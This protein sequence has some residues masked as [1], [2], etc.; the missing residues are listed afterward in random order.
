MLA[1]DWHISQIYQYLTNIF[2]LINPQA[3]LG[4]MP[5]SN[6]HIFLIKP[7]SQVGDMPIFSQH[8]F[9][10]KPA[11]GQVG[12]ILISNQHIYSNQIKL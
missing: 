3:Q 2:I 12:D 9:L 7:Q 4:D 6:Q 1:K 5:I 8:F 10:I 11:Q